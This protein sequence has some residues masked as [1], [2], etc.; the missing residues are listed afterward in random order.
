MV[1]ELCVCDPSFLFKDPS[2]NLALP[3]SSRPPEAGAR[4]STASGYS[5]A[6]Y[7]QVTRLV[8]KM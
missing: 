7:A 3:S 6:A 2:T 5:K 1:S 4:H 8:V